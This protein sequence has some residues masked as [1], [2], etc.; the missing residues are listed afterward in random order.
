[1]TIQGW[2]SGSS[3]LLTCIL[4]NEKEVPAIALY[5][6]RK[7][8]LPEKHEFRTGYDYKTTDLQSYISEGLVTLIISSIILLKSSTSVRPSLYSVT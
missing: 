5:S 4:V 3:R 2:Q 8:Q 1:V 6:R 7:K